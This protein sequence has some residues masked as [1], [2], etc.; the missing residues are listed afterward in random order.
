[1]FWTSHGYES[2]ATNI[3]EE[4]ETE[5]SEDYLMFVFCDTAELFGA[6]NDFSTFNIILYHSMHHARE[7][8]C[9]TQ[10]QSRKH[11]KIPDCGPLEYH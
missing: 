5:N 6:G 1:M 2:V 3:M 10:K 7:H 9:N 4:Q 8:V 11:Q